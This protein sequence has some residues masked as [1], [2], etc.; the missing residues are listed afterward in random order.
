MK[1]NFVKREYNGQLSIAAPFKSVL[2]S[3]SDEVRNC[4]NDAQTPYV[5]ANIKSPTGET[6]GATYFGD[7]AKLLVGGTVDCEITFVSGD[8]NAYHRVLWME[9]GKRLTADDYGI[10]VAE[11]FA[12][13]PTEVVE[14]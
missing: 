3:V 12:S 14:A 11:L 5:V 1:L 4:K 2:I 13:A 6:V 8:D 7:P 10:D 9:G